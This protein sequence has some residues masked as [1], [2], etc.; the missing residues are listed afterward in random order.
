MKKYVMSQSKVG[1]SK[2][3]QAVYNSR[4]KTYAKQAIQDLTLLAQQLP[5]DQQE[6]IF[7]HKTLQPLFSAILKP[8][9]QE[10]QQLYQDKELAKK[11]RQ[12]LLPICYGIISQLNDSNLAHILAPIGTRYMVK[13][14][15][16]LA[17]LK[18]IYY[19]SFNS[20]DEE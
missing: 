4:I 1:Y 20:D 17:F 16:H 6:E 19:R 12:T 2:E 14:G 7:N 13:E 18:A 11:K 3:V 5:Q 9:A 8:S 10:I 15:G